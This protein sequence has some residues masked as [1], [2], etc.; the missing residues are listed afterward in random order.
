MCAVGIDRL[1]HVFME[2]GW[3][4]LTTLRPIIVDGASLTVVKYTAS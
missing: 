2:N 4:K 3:I 1:S